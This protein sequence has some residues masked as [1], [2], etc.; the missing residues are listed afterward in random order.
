MVRYSPFVSPRSF[1]ERSKLIG[2]LDGGLILFHL[3]LRHFAQPLGVLDKLSPAPSTAC[4]GAHGASNGG[5]DEHRCEQPSHSRLVH[6]PSPSGRWR[7]A[8]S[9]RCSDASRS[10]HG[11][12]RDHGR[13][14]RHPWSRCCVCVSSHRGG[15]CP[16]IRRVE[17]DPR[18]ARMHTPVLRLPGPLC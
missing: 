8:A 12:G 5:I 2:L 6:H 7:N 10:S 16:A 11:N 3:P 14:V 18:C 15:R 17:H 1:C 9:S 13:S 4:F